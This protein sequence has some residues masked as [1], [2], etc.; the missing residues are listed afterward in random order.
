MRKVNSVLVVVL[1]L[2]VA[3]CAVQRHGRL[4][5]VVSSEAD[6][7]TCEQVIIEI[8]KCNAFIKEVSGKNRKFTGGDVLAF[9]GDFGIG[10]SWEVSD[11]IASA[12]KR[13]SQLEDIRAEKCEGQLAIKGSSVTKCSVC[14][15]LGGKDSQWIMK[16]GKLICLDCYEKIEASKEKTKTGSRVY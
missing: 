3:G 12:T 10:D 4:I 5:P 15:N 13:I 2:L 9:L 16:D 11:A 1:L 8:D 6:S 14:G 7:Y